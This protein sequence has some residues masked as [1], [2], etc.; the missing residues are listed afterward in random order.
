MSE[1]DEYDRRMEQLEKTKVKHL[2]RIADALEKIAAGALVPQKYLTG[3]DTEHDVIETDQGE[4]VLPPRLDE[5]SL[6]Y[7]NQEGINHDRH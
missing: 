1:V 7:G 4:V 3:L 6:R 2:R 5:W